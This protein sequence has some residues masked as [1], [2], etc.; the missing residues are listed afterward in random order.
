V[1]TSSA[2]AEEE[3]VRAAL[4]WTVAAALPSAARMRSVLSES[5]TAREKV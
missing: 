4:V 2:C 5:R 3:R 1:K